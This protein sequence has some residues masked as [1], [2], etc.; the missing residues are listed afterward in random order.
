MTLR[1]RI[2]GRLLFVP[3][4]LGYLYGPRLMSALRKLWVRARHPHATIRF[5][6]GTYLGPGFS[7]HVPAAATFIAGPG[8]E[9]RRSFRCELFPGATVTIGGGCG[10][11][12]Y[13]LIQCGGRIEIGD[14]CMF[15]QSA[16]VVDGNHRFRDLTKPMLA[17]GFD[18]RPIRIENDVTTT[19]K[20]TIMANIGTRTFVGANS[21]V[22]RDLPAYVVAV[23]APAR[24]IDY[25]GP[26]GTEPPELNRSSSETRGATGSPEDSAAPASSQAERKSEASA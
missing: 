17:Q 13:A 2:P 6:K 18:L 10:F 3:R 1:E 23:G 20:C 11:S 14:R 9:F 19:T 25:F 7:L 24:P 8:C 5:G 15:G 26:P 21:V 22:S 12:Y 4:D 16:M